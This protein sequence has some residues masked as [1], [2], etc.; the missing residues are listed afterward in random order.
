VANQRSLSWESRFDL[1]HYTDYNLYGSFELVRSVRAL[2]QEGYAATLIG[3]RNV[4]YPPWIVRGGVMVGLPSAPQLPM[5]AGVEA[6]IVGPR[7]AA[8]ASIV[9]RG[10]SYDLPT[11]FVLD[12]TLAT[13]AL[14]LVRGQETRVALRGKNILGTRGPDPG[15]AGFDYPLRPTELVLELRHSL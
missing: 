9:E 5:D 15:F 2:G 1:K 3:A 6:M 14:Y 12:A 8:D 11:Y 10:A 4:V 13:R 7:R